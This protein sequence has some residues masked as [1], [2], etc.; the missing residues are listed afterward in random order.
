[1]NSGTCLCGD[2]AWQVDGDFTVFTNCHCSIC[3][4]THGAA[5]VGFVA[6]AADNF[7]WTRGEDTIAQY[8]S[9]GKGQRGFCPRCGSSVPS[10]SETFAFMPAG[11]LDGDIGVELNSHIFV[12]SKADWCDISDDV[13]QFDEYPPGWEMEVTE[14]QPRL[15]ATDG[16]VAGSCDCGKIRFEFDGPGMRMGSCHCSR[17]RKARSAAFSTQVFAPADRFRWLS[18]E[19]NARDYHLPGTKYFITTFCSDC[20]SPVPKAFEEFGVF[21]IPAGA[22]DGDPGVRPEA[23][24]YVGS[25]APWHIITDDLPQFEEMSPG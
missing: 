10:V 2:I 12:K 8:A 25:K 21:M 19:E 13:P 20:G 18:G 14:R 4:K 1:M 16:A 22:L 23:H 17:C 15:P 9:S 5:Y 6:T 11:N 7:K 3:R 24:I